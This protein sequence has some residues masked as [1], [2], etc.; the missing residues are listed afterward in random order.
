VSELDVRLS[1]LFRAAF[2]RVED[3]NFSNATRDS[4][5]EWDSIAAVTLVTLVEEEFGQQFDLEDAAEWT[6]YQQIRDALQERLRA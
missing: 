2:P 6:S 3:K 4:I 5:A 1:A